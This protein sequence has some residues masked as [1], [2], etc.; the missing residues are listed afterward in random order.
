[1]VFPEGLE[2]LSLAPRELEQIVLDQ[3]GGEE[4]CAAGVESLEDHLGVLTRV[5]IDLDQDQVP[6]HGRAQRIEPRLDPAIPRIRSRP[7]V[8]RGAEE[9]VRLV[10][11][12]RPGERAHPVAHRVVEGA[13]IA[14]RRDDLVLVTLLAQVVL[15]I[16]QEI[17]EGISLQFQTVLDRDG[18]RRG[19]KQREGREPLLA[20]DHPVRGDAGTL[21]GGR[22]EDDRSEK[23]RDVVVRIRVVELALGD[24][25]DVLPDR[26]PLLLALP[27]VRALIERNQVL[28]RLLEDLREVDLVRPHRVITL[29]VL[30]P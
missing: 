3:V 28:D 6:P 24:R 13:E 27:D 14:C 18:P 8:D 9:P 10:Q 1:M 4:R 29:A 23:V 5:E 12:V 15:P 16:E 21:R 22:P 30:R 7:V 20:I 25:P 17:G 11:W 19:D 26:D 2:V